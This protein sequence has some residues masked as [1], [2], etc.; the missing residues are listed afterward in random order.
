MTSITRLAQGD[1][2]WGEAWAEHRPPLASASLWSQALP[3]GPNAELPPLGHSS[4]SPARTWGRWDSWQGVPWPSA[5]AAL[6]QG[7]DTEPGCCW[8]LPGTKRGVLG[9][10]GLAEDHVLLSKALQTD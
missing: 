6:A 3:L 10:G 8:L 2:D 9:V 4:G 1:Q 7:G 5:Q